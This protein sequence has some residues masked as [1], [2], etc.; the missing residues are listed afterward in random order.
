MTNTAEFDWLRSRWATSRKVLA[1]IAG[2]QPRKVS[3]WRKEGLPWSALCLYA[4][5]FEGIQLHPEQR[6]SKNHTWQD[7][8]EVPTSFTPTVSVPTIKPLPWIDQWQDG[9]YDGPSLGEFQ[10]LLEKSSLE[11]KDLPNIVHEPLR[12]L[13]VWSLGQKVKMPYWCLFTWA[14]HCFGIAI[15][16]GNWREE[17]LR[18]H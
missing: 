2:T 17:L 16:P 9:K 15:S 3:K 5:A 12:K 18:Y 1:S 11:L 4:Y 6:F 14:M 8:L 7:V 10:L 13:R